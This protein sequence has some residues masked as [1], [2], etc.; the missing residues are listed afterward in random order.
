MATAGW[1]CRSSTRRRRSEP[2]P[3]TRRRTRWAYA[4][5]CSPSTTSTTSLPAC[6]ATAPSSWAK[7][8]STGTATGC[9]SCVARRASSSDWP[10]RSGH[11]A[12]S[13]RSSSNRCVL[14]GARG[15]SSAPGDQIAQRAEV[16][17]R[18]VAADAHDQMLHAG[19][20]E[21][22]GVAQ[23]V[24]V[25]GPCALDLGRIAPDV[26]AVLK[27]DL[28]LAPERVGIT[29]AVPHVRVLGNELQRD[30]RAAA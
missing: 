26:L 3:K 23:Q 29:E 20:D 7:W 4:G 16:V 1:S 2:S 18:A 22:I 14:I 28:V 27:E 25:E 13:E 21:R 24:A 11:R 5:S 17:A 8:P 15:P 9:P 6:A 19:G 10:S 30:L 12:E